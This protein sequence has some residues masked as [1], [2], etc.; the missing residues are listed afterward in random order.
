MVLESHKLQ[1]WNKTAADRHIT[2]GIFFKVKS[3]NFGALIN[4]I[5]QTYK[6]SL[7]HLM[8]HILS[9]VRS[10]PFKNAVFFFFRISE[11]TH[12]AKSQP[13]LFWFVVEIT[14][15]SAWHTAVTSTVKAKK[16]EKKK[17]K[18]HC[19]RVGTLSWGLLCPDQVLS[20]P[21]ASGET[22]IS[23]WPEP[24]ISHCLVCFCQNTL[25]RH[26]SCQY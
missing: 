11:T 13:Q 2:E 14:T 19:W 3:I 12:T 16:P 8:I 18:D 22:T 26:K 5:H 10:W 17:E 4:I 9:S 24:E 20:H 1:I 25:G 15:A 23:G 6:D 21:C 7:L